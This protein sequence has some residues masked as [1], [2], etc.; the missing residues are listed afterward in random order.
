M[1]H[2]QIADIKL[3]ILANVALV[4][5]LGQLLTKFLK[6]VGYENFLYKGCLDKKGGVK[7]KK[8]GFKPNCIQWCNIL[9]AIS[10]TLCVLWL[11]P[12]LHLPSVIMYM[13]LPVLLNSLMWDGN[14]NKH[15][16]WNLNWNKKSCFRIWWCSFKEDLSISN[17]TSRMDFHTVKTPVLN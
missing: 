16:T 9:G 14:K 17:Q 13:L 3:C 10:H 4:L 7:I 1:A 2:A 12:H 5:Y 15:E 8:V 6:R 11:Y